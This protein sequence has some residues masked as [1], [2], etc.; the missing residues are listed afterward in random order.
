MK[1]RNFKELAET[2]LR[3]A[4]LEIAEAGLDAIDTEKYIKK[5]VI[6]GENT[7]SV[8]GRE[9]DLS[10]FERIFVVG[11]G[12]CA[13]EAGRALEEILGE[14][15]NG[16][17]VLDVHEG[18]LNKIKTFAGAHPFPEP[19]NI[20]A[21]AEI[22]K[23]LSSLAEK[24]FVLFVISGGGSTLLCQ[25]KELVCQ[26]EKDILQ[27]L[28]RAGANIEETN[29]VRKHLSLARGGHLAAYAYPATSVALIFSDVRGSIEFVAS[30][31]TVKDTT[32]VEDARL[33]LE[34]YAIEKSIGLKIEPLETP[35][36]NKFFEKMANIV[37][38]DN[39]T[40]LSA[41]SEKAKELGF[42]ADIH[43]NILEGE[44][45]DVGKEIAENLHKENRKTCVLYGGET[46][47]CV[48]GAG[49][50]GRNQE[51]AM[52]AL[53][54]V[55]EREL[56]LSFASDG[57]DNTDFAGALCDKITSEKAAKLGLKPEE[58]LKNNDSYAFFKEVGDYLLTGDTGSNVS[59]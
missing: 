49:K 44:A 56:I 18:S 39:I 30:G 46:T 20:D 16:G 11:V 32:T 52:G 4:A 8:K 35:K 26:D 19:R 54:E 43:T 3:K 58:F 40:A 57:R 15:L 7:L 42:D 10:H 37:F 27:A 50:G 22:I 13:L 14:K 47:V 12:K 6:L 38:M 41:M 9:F 29:T 34:K 25:P 36:G 21:T 55:G 1:I 17:I 24:D 5:E 28:F 48:K 59:D 53:G 45:R 33:V 51:V 2:D 23:L 31:P